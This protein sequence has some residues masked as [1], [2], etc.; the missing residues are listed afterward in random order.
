VTEDDED[1]SRRRLLALLG[2]FLL[3]LLGAGAGT[4]NLLTGGGDG[5]EET[6]LT[7]SVDYSV[8]P[9]PP[10]TPTPEADGTRDGTGGTTGAGEGTDPAA[11]SDDPTPETTGVGTSSPA[12]DSLGGDDTDDGSLGDGDPSPAVAPPTDDAVT[13]SV[14]P[15]SVA[16]V[17]PGD[18]GT[19]D[20]SLDL[21]GSPAR[22]WVRADATDFAENGVVESERDAGDAGPPGDLQEHVRVRLWYDADDD[23]AL[24]RG[25]RVVYDGTLADLDA[26]S[27]WTA[28]T[29]VCVPPG[30]HA[31]RFRWS[32]PVDAPSTVQTDGATFSLGVAAE[33]SGCA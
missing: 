16:D 6:G 28:L 5:D 3:A 33:A 32:L 17:S 4:L 22:L 13:S 7:L 15:V 24:G 20:L 30:S 21:S 23:G 12:D 27:E 19:V 26:L 25:E 10:S 9:D 1:S 2:A 8:T 18:G 31:V 11:G 29:D 14:P